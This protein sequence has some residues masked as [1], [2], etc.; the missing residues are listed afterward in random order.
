MV[1]HILDASSQ[2]H[3]SNWI[4]ALNVHGDLLPGCKFTVACQQ[5]NLST[6]CPL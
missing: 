2:E 1:T 5:L 4:R 6:E 3:I